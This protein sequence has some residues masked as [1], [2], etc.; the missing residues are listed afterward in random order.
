MKL[1]INPSLTF[2]MIPISYKISKLKK[3]NKKKKS[4]WQRE[5]THNS[6]PTLTMTCMKGSKFWMIMTSTH[7]T[8][9]K[10]KRTMEEALDFSSSQTLQLVIKK[11][12]EITILRDKKE[13]SICEEI[14]HITY[15]LSIDDHY[16]NNNIHFLNIF[17]YLQ[18]N[19]FPIL[20]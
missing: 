18:I 16:I 5:I 10:T 3:R 19:L 9:W 2:S 13:Q 8:K 15:Q 6:I 20:F 7:L 1:T 14:K 11:R 12:M 17:T 4:K